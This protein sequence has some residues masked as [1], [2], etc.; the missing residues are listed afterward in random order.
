MPP[1]SD[2]NVKLVG[3]SSG[4]AY[5]ALGPTHHSIEDV[6]WT[7][8]IADLIVI[9]PADPVDTRQAVRPPHEHRRSHVHPHQPHARADRP[10][11]RLPLPYRAGGAAA[12]RRRRHAH[13]QR[14]HGQSGPGCGRRAGRPDGIE[15]RVLDMATV[16]PIDR[17]AIVAAAQRDARHRDR[18][19]AHRAR[20]TGRRGRGGRRHRAA[21]CRCASW[22]SR[23]SPRPGR[24][25]SCSS[26]S[27]SPRPGIAAAARELVDA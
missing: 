24:R 10:R 5:G 4:V 1:T 22:A 27:A 17:E 20:R 12:R 14:R 2:A 26:T 19:G 11:A 16:S 8:A 7:R 13:R 3:V 9:V 23:A 6:A 15:A 25:S 18:R 21:R